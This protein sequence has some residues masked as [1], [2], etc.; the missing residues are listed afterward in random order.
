MA[1]AA[2]GH[3]AWNTVSQGSQGWCVDLPYHP[4]AAFLNAGCG[5]GRQDGPQKVLLDYVFNALPSRYDKQW[6]WCD[7]REFNWNLLCEFHNSSVP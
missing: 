7:N 5:F 1:A 4:N 6:W 3:C 2:G